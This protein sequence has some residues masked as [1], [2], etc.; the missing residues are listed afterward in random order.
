M[1]VPPNL[2]GPQHSSVSPFIVPQSGSAAV[3]STADQ[4]QAS[5][6]S[7]SSSQ[8]SSPEKLSSPIDVVDSNPQRGFTNGGRQS[9]E[10]DDLISVTPESL[11]M[12]HSSSGFIAEP[13]NFLHS[14]QEEPQSV[15]VIGTGDSLIPASSSCDSDLQHLAG[16][17][18]NHKIKTL[19]QISKEKLLGSIANYDELE[20]TSSED[21]SSAIYTSST[22]KMWPQDQREPVLAKALRVCGAERGLPAEDMY[23]EQAESSQGSTQPDQPTSQALNKDSNSKLTSANRTETLLGCDDPN[24]EQPPHSADSVPEDF[25]TFVIPSARHDN[26]IKGNS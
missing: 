21:S 11:F 8:H 2:G 13:G 25:A 7:A 3:D 15:I 26:F 18:V 1:S 24:M 20:A 12:K 16:S 14:Q 17:P 19:D 10:G 22:F 23:I 6:T 5:E 9:G 4:G